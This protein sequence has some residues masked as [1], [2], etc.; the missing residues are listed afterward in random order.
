MKLMT[1]EAARATMLA[2]V[3]PLGPVMVPLSEA[4]GRVL[5]SDIAAVRDQP[6][7]TNSAMD[8][9]AVKASLQ[10]QTLQIIGESAAGRRRPRTVRR[11]AQIRDPCQNRRR[12][13]RSN[14]WAG[15]CRY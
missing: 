1:V 5:A 8:G 12:A 9:W 3:G 13:L 4:M 14:L 2:E 7:F 6:P 10:A 15:H 11:T